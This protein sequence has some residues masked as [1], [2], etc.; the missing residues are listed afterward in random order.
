[1]RRRIMPCATASAVARLS[2]GAS[3]PR[4]ASPAPL[5]LWAGP[6]LGTIALGRVACYRAGQAPT[7]PSRRWRLG[8]GGDARSRARNRLFPSSPIRSVHRRPLP[9][10]HLASIRHPGSLMHAHI[11]AH[12]R[13]AL[14]VGRRSPPM[15]VSP[16]AGPRRATRRLRDAAAPTSAGA[17]RSFF[18]GGTY[19][20]DDTATV[21]QAS[22]LR[23]PAQARVLHCVP[24]LTGASGSARRDP[25]HAGGR[26][27]SRRCEEGKQTW[28]PSDP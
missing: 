16:R 28:L 27:G 11:P 5:L 6:S 19:P 15:G 3:A 7:R 4:M 8:P 1:M 22:P 20:A 25:A 10:A 26:I 13:Y 21:R 9:L 18:L 17:L 2:A 23:Q 14:G 24:A 12:R